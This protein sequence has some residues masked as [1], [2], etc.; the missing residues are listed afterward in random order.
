MRNK[1][2]K[3]RNVNTKKAAYKATRPLLRESYTSAQQAGGGG[4]S[5]K[6]NANSIL[7]V[8]IVEN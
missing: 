2:E 8:R 7:G 6:N 5:P 1:M 3:S 4:P